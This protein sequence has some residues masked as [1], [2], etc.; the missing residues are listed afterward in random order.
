MA[1]EYEIIHMERAIN[2]FK[3]KVIDDVEKNIIS[4]V[5]SEYIMREL[6]NENYPVEYKYGILMGYYMIEYKNLRSE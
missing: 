3:N 2:H 5:T 6:N 4:Y 1:S